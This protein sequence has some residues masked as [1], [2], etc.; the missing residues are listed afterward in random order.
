MD[1]FPTDN[2]VRD[3]SPKTSMDN[4]PRDN[5]SINIA[6]FVKIY[7]FLSKRKKMSYIFLPPKPPTERR[8]HAPNTFGLTAPSQLVIRYHWLPF[9]NQDRKNL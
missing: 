8:P 2:L 9:L 3:N 4:L 5:S 6:F 1:N 7:E